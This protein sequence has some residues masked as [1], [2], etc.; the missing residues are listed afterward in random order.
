[1]A[2]V[3]ASPRLRAN[4]GLI[5]HLACVAA[6]YLA[7]CAQVKWQPQNGRILL[8]MFVLAA[9]AVGTALAGLDGRRARA[10]V[11]AAFL[12]LP[13][14]ALPALLAAESR[15][16]LGH[17]RS[18]R[19]SRA[20][21]L[22]SRC[23][24]LR[25]P[26]QKAARAIRQLAWQN[27]GLD[28]GG[29]MGHCEYA[30]WYLLERAG[31]RVRLEHVNV[32]GPSAAL[33]GSPPWDTFVP[34]G[35][36]FLATPTRPRLPSTTL[37][38]G[39]SYALARPLGAV[40]L[41]APEGQEAGKKRLEWAF[42]EALDGVRRH[43]AGGGSW[44][45]LHT[46]RPTFAD[47]RHEV[48]LYLPALMVDVLGPV[49]AE[50]CLTDVVARGRA[51]LARQIEETGLARYY[52]RP[53]E[54][55]LRRP[56]CVITPDSDSTALA[57][58]LTA[59]GDAARRR[60]ALSVLKQYRTEEGLYRTWLAEPDAVRCVHAGRNPNPP[61]VGIQMHLYQ[62]LAQQDP[63]AARSLCAALGRA[64][65]EERIWVYYGAAPLVPLLREVDLARAGCP[66][67]VPEIRLRQVDADQEAIMRLGRLLRDLL[68][69]AE[70]P[71]IVEHALEAL[72]RAAAG[73]MADAMRT[74][75]LLYH[76]DFS[77]ATP[78]FYWS[79]DFG[80]ALWIRTY[81]ETARRWPGSVHVPPCPL[82]TP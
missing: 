8:P 62:L 46:P 9:P 66:L 73:G 27:V 72:D 20:D 5:V 12:A 40:G 31:P 48:N 11:T 74:P 54:P 51:Y 42:R 45:T 22:F 81:I 34:D 32:A 44:E 61:D 21:L 49:A 79:K 3:I 14:L 37:H 6:G 76:N 1:V 71:P 77:A 50:T 24:H 41:Y 59:D 63:E 10:V 58:R 30:L 69:R 23:E 67:R 28:F 65:P 38:R 7:F 13:L 15:A 68:L 82:T 18:L 53:D 78:R 80:D 60:S 39:A 56:R 16:I 19:S 4:R 64:L 70:P 33:A 55:Q 26:Y 57:W 75:P 2:V 25:A 43:Q 36:V 52:G 35:I 17:E 29:F 47:A